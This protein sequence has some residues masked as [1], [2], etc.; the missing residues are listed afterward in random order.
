MHGF[1]PATRLNVIKLSHAAVVIMSGGFAW[2]LEPQR[3]CCS[4]MLCVA[5]E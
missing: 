3:A 1:I 4:G 5:R 2:W